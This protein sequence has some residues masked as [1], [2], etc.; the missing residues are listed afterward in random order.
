MAEK[1]KEGEE[2]DKEETTMDKDRNPAKMPYSI[3]DTVTDELVALEDDPVH[4]YPRVKT[5]Q[6]QAKLESTSLLKDVVVDRVEKEEE[7]EDIFS[8]FQVFTAA[9]Q[10]FAHGANDTA[11]AM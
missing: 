6:P 3:V 10:S 2:L 7:V 8:F 11:N 4:T 1:E 9:F 5:S